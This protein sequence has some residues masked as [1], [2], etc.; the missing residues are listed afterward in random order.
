MDAAPPDSPQRLAVLPAL[1]G[2]MSDR[3]MADANPLALPMTLQLDGTTIDPDAPPPAGAVGGRLLSILKTQLKSST[4][5]RA[6]RSSMFSA[7]TQRRM[8]HGFVW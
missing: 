8:A 1:N 6:S 2:V 3:L 4:R 7:L 5:F